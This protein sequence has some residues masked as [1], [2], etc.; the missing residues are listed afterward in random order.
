MSRCPCEA[1]RMTS[2]PQ[3]SPATVWFPWMES[4]SSSLVASSSTVYLDG[5]LGDQ[6]VWTFNLKVPSFLKLSHR[7]ATHPDLEKVF[8][9]LINSSVA[10]G[11]SAEPCVPVHL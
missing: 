2:E 8:T 11:V 10:L 6:C 9:V 7:R 4:G 1:Y 5:L 3:F